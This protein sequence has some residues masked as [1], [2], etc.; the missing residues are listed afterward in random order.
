MSLIN[1]SKVITLHSEIVI[2]P[3][4][5]GAI[6]GETA[7]GNIRELLQSA[8]IK[9]ILKK[10]ESWKGPICKEELLIETSLRDYLASEYLT[11]HF[12]EIL[13]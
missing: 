3:A 1:H 4:Y 8:T 2:A 6:L 11:L 9:E 13:L 7:K 10:Q 5:I 12:Q